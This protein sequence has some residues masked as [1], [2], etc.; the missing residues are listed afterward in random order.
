MKND[1]IDFVVMW[2]DGND[3]ESQKEK[4]KYSVHSTA[5]GSI[6]R[7]R[8]FGLL[9]YWFRGI[10]KFAP[11]VNKVYFITWGHVP[12]WLDLNHP[13]LKIVKHEDFIPKKYLPTFSA[14]TIETNIFR[15]KELSEHFVLFNDDVYIINHVKPFDFFYKGIP[16]DTVA[17]N[18]HCP[19]KSLISQYFAINDTSIIN[20]HFD[21]K[22][23]FKE[24][25]KRWY[26]LKNG[27]MLLRTLVLKQ[28]PR[29]PGFWQPHLTTSL[30]KSIME[31]VWNQEYEILD[32]TCSHKFREITDVNQWLFRE[33]QIASGYFNNRTIRF[34]RSYFI[35]RDGISNIHD[36]LIKYICKQKGK[37]ISINDGP[38][39]D[40]DFTQILNDLNKAFEEILPDKC[41]FERK[42]E[43]CQKSKHKK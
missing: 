13:K 7:Y 6:Y 16:Q 30:C 3:P 17:L 12:D 43:K 34:G 37:V 38:M 11:W 40:K 28:C 39:S 8:D 5:D 25:K 35:D 14:N 1:A 20:E 33:W 18:V 22:K 4:N 15:I 2:A 24:N 23:S 29:F 26:S 31:E 21:F 27:K 41:S 36:S 10:E 32:N 19:K 42:M 9:K